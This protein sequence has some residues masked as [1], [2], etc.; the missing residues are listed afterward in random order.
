MTLNKVALPWLILALAFL[1]GCSASSSHLA[2][3]GLPQSNSVGAFRINNGS[4]KFTSIV[5]SPFLA[6]NSPGPVIVAPSKSFLY[7][8]NRTDDTISLFKIDGDIGSLKEITPRVNTGVAPNSMVMDADGKFLF[9]GNETSHSIS[10][11]SIDSGSGALKEVKGSPF[12]TPPNPVSLAVTP[13]G[14]FLY[15]VNSN[16]Q[17]VF[18]YAVGSDGSLQSVPG[19]QF[20]VGEGAFAIAVDPGGKFVYVA[21]SAEDT[22]SIFSIA[23]TGALNPITDSPFPTG[24]TPLAIVLSTSGQYLYLANHGSNNVTAYSIDSTSGT[25]TAVSGSPFSATTQAVSLAADPNG[26]V[27]YVLGQDPTIS[28]LSITSSTGA[29]T[30][31]TQSATAESTPVS[32]FVTK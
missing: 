24:T 4:G 26:K 12:L 10:V 7:V 14:S 25:P 19:S 20:A 3:V 15:I 32:I 6:G 27:L 11:Y 21:N 13:S 31:G 1:A 18:G 23:S 29:L 9:V 8:A 28:T 22:V 2:Y 16:L 17:L 5:G 30:S